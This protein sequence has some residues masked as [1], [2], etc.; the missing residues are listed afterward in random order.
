[1][2]HLMIS[3]LMIASA[4]AMADSGKG[5]AL[6]NSFGQG[7]LSIHFFGNA[8]RLLYRDLAV[9]EVSGVAGST[10][11]SSTVTCTKTQGD[12]ICSISVDPKTG[13]VTGP[14]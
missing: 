4:T 6:V 13:E 12:Y 14:Q 10:K 7:E 2:K 11:Q 9:R 8:A 5:R 3:Y 1:M